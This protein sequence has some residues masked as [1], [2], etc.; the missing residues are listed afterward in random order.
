MRFSSRIAGAMFWLTLISTS[1]Q[2]YG[3]PAPTPLAGPG[4]PVDWLFVFKFNS[5]TYP[6][7]ICRGG[8][9]E[10]DSPGL[11]GGT[12]KP[13]GLAQEKWA[14]GERLDGLLEHYGREVSQSRVPSD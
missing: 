13:Y 7:Q 9:P 6:D 1:V 5:A 2:T 12:V 4:K 11:F 3:Q 10:E 14:R 8:D